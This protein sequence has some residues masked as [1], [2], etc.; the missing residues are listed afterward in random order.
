[1]RVRR[2]F[3]ACGTLLLLSAAV[4]QEA[5]PAGEQAVGEA[6]AALVITSHGRQVFDITT[7]LTTLPDGGR[8]YDALTDVE[9]EAALIEYVEG[10]YIDAS[11]VVV[12]GQ[13]G[14]FQSESMHVDLVDSVL[15]ASGDLWLA[16]EGLTVTAGSLQYFAEED[17]MVFNGGVK[18]SEPDFYADRLLLDVE[19]G[20]VLLDGRYTFAG[21]VFT[22]RSPE[23]GGRL[24]LEPQMSG[25]EYVYAAATEVSPELLR[26]FSAY[27]Y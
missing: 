25:E 27:L 24:H 4:A 22:L 12:T 3:V 1:M 13:F 18:G 14:S 19:T 20:D 8:I 5:P 15:S 7:G 17:M 21:A 11:G 2:L 6:F 26:R 10:Q 16:R 23:A 9:V